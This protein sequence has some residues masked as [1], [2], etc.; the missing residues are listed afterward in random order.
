LAEERYGRHGLLG[1]LFRWG[2]VEEC[3][4]DRARLQAMLEFES[5]LARAEASAGVIPA[6]AARAISAR[7]AADLFDAGA[8]AQGAAR[9]GNLAIPLVKA[10]TAL[11]GRDDP[12]AARFVHFGATSQDAIDT[13][14]VLQLRPALERIEE[15]LERLAGV[16]AALVRA[17]RSTLVAA[18]TWMQ[19]AAPTSF[20]LKV[21][22]WLD[23]VDRHRQRLA[24]VRGRALVLQL[25]GAVG[26]LAALGNRGVAVATALAE[27]LGLPRPALAWHTH[28]DRPAEV[29]TILGLCAGTLGKIARDVA[30]HMQTEV[31][32]VFEPA[33]DER[34]GSS[35]M[36]HKRNPVTSAVVLAA[37]ARVPGLVAS[38]LS[39]MVQEEERGLGGWHAEWEVLPELVGLVG[40]AIHHL[41]ETMAGLEV[42]AAR[43][44]A[45]LEATN[46]LVFAEAVQMALREKAGAGEARELVE[47]SCR[48]SRGEGRHLREV[49]A[50]DP[51]IG[52]HLS[53]ADLAGLFDPERYLGAAHEMIDAVLAAHSGRPVKARVE[54]G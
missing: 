22:G 28:R 15:E 8:L 36:P 9:A 34:G 27:D 4:S 41:A 54:G 12:A 50:A 31:A 23:A 3:F 16:L 25:G 32:E 39:A 26:S 14:L 7:C 19:Q 38:M 51:E 53:S 17:H 42:D 21:A 6:A 1:P 33:G 20:G 5:A 18:R 44:R 45:N 40:G 24:D 13:G 30:L 2:A 46:G 29:A 43:M 10:L 35:T 49:L 52:K 37:A 47:R 48:R 11:V